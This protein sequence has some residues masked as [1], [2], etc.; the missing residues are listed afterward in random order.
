M[1]D[2]TRMVQATRPGNSVMQNPQQTSP[3]TAVIAC[4]GSRIDVC[5]QCQVSV[6]GGGYMYLT[7]LL[8]FSAAEP[9]ASQPLIQFN[10]NNQGI[11]VENLIYMYLYVI[12]YPLVNCWFVGSGGL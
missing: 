5:L 8:S 7:R 10:S 3:I 9:T 6:G 11:G 2:D 1:S 12:P 4:E